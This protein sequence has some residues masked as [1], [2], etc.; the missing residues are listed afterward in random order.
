MP[1]TEDTCRWL[2]T[3]DKVGVVRLVRC[4][5]RYHFVVVCWVDVLVDAVSCQ[6]YL[7]KGTFSSQL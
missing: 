7:L 6:L 4:E 3:L 2:V 5:D 1:Y